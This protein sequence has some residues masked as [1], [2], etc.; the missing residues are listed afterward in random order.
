MAEFQADDF[1]I[2]SPLNTL[3]GLE[4]DIRC[5]LVDIVTLLP[6]LFAPSYS[7]HSEGGNDNNSNEKKDESKDGARGKQ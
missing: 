5:G 2:T 7:Q 3:G 6:S 4:C 1:K